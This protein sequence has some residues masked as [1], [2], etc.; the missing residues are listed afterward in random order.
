MLEQITPTTQQLSLSRELFRKLTHLFALII[1]AGYYF[2]DLSRAT[3]LVVLLPVTVLVIAVDIS[4]LQK[5]R[6][7][8]AIGRPWF[9]S[10]IRPREM[11]SNFTGASYILI[12]VCLVIALFSKP[13]A[14][15]AMVFVIVG[16][17]LAALVGRTA[18]R[19]R[20]FGEKSLEGTLACLGGTALVAAVLPDLPLPIALAGA[21]SAT[22]AEAAPLG[23]DDNISV[24]LISALVMSIAYKVLTFS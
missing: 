18:G 7:W 24:P 22:I 8:D 9:G 19:L 14:V 15:G 13:I 2:L 23:V 5:G 20:L 17:M 3:A 1:P 16:D 6:L 21:I 11:A 10:I 4:R 12:S